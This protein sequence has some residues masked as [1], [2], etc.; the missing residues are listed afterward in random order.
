[1]A[2]LTFLYP[3]YWTNT[4]LYYFK[5][6]YYCRRGQLKYRSCLEQRRDVTWLVEIRV[7]TR[8]A[9]TEVLRV[10]RVRAL[11]RTFCMVAPG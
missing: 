10:P 6:T 9:L 4:S 8:H 11:A 3:S 7:A 2:L 1:M 5:L